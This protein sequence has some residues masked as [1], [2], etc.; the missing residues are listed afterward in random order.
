MPL[1]VCPFT[2]YYDG[3]R[4]I[5]DTRLKSRAANDA[6]IARYLLEKMKYDTSTGAKP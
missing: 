6:I 5:R 2:L 3:S 1:L 4:S